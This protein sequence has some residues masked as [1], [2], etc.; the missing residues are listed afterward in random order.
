MQAMYFKLAH[1]YFWA[2]IVMTIMFVAVKR[3]S[4]TFIQSIT[5]RYYHGGP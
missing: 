2:V 5:E 4:E 3:E 1:F